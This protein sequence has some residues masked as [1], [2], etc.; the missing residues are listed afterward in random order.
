MGRLLSDKSKLSGK[1][2]YMTLNVV[3]LMRTIPELGFKN[4]TT[5]TIVHMTIKPQEIVD[6]EDAKSN[7]RDREGNE[8]SPAC[9]CVIQ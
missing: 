1:R 6:E 3:M 5:P 4:V 7:T 8:R 2:S 9:R